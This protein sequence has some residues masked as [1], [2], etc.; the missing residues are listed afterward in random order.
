MKQRIIIKNKRT[1]EK[2][3][4]NLSE[5]KNRFNSE[6][7]TAINNLKIQEN[8]KNFFPSFMKSNNNHELDFYHNLRWNFNNL[9]NSNWYI[10]RIL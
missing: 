7:R 2:L 9:Q 8:K 6:I 3:E 4:L 10:E 1:R 5:F